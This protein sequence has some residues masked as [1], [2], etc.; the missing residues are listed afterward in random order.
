MKEI[1]K[2]QFTALSSGKVVSG[3]GY[4]SGLSNNDLEIKPFNTIA[5]DNNISLPVT[6]GLE[7]LND[8]NIKVKNN[9]Q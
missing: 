7:W 6:V 3:R 9:K 8:N 2:S 4:A 1:L 5:K